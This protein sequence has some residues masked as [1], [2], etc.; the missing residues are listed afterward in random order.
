VN[1]LFLVKDIFYNPVYL[2]ERN[3]YNPTCGELYSSDWEK[4]IIE[5]EKSCHKGKDETFKNC[6]RNI[7]TRMLLDK[8]KTKNS[9]PNLSF[10]DKL[11]DLT[12]WFINSYTEIIKTDQ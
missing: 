2:T 1:V 5:V 10:S 11:V 7:N 6:E 4:F 8:I 3:S 12:R 9:E